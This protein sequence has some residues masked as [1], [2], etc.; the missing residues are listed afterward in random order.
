MVRYRRNFIAGGTFFFTLTLVNR[1]SRV[2]VDHV[3]VLRSATRG[4]HNLHPFLIDAAVVLPDHLHIVMT[5]PEGDADYSTRLS[6]IKRRFTEHLI[7]AGV[8]VA[9]RA[10]GEIALWNRRFWEHTIRDDRDFERHVDYIHYN[11]VRY[12]F[13]ARVRDWPHSSFHR[14]VERGILPLD[15][16]GEFTDE[17]GSFGERRGECG[18]CCPGFGKAREERAIARRKT[19][20]TALWLQPGLRSHGVITDP[21]ES[22]QS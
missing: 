12:G 18:C 13:V 19:R 6:L 4:V 9:R 16:G 22:E 17:Q 10:N 8:T 21:C 20:V 14:Y 3:D 15:W 7:K 5:L 11:P 2:L 1:T